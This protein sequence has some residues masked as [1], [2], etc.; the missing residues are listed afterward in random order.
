[1]PGLIECSSHF[2]LCHLYEKITASSVSMAPAL[3]FT[4]MAS[5]HTLSA[6]TLAALLCLFCLSWKRKREAVKY[7]QIIFLHKPFVCTRH[8]TLKQ[9][10]SSSECNHINMDI[11]GTSSRNV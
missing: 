2:F 8:N 10:G 9:L 1:M 7:T 6:L 5:I 4:V 3:Y 11:S